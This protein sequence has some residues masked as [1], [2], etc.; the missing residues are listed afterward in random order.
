[1]RE[2]ADATRREFSLGLS[3]HLTLLKAYDGWKLARSCGSRAENEFLR[4]HFLSRH[5]LNL[6][7]D[8]RRQFRSL[9]RDVGFIEGGESRG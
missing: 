4:D 5:T 6:V 9:L 3:D 7:H 1:R 2:E 8:M